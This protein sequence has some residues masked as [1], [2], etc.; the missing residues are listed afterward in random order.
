MTKFN[1]R[2]NLAGKGYTLNIE[3][4][5]EEIFRRAEKDVNRLMATVE[6]QYA[7]EKED[8]LATVALQF[9]VKAIELETSR[10]LGDEVEELK[11]LDR[12]LGSYL[13]K[14]K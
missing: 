10:T 1:I 4:D 7:A 14:L 8:Y 13:D 9:A 2:L 5:R 6:S 11:E 3:R 12:E